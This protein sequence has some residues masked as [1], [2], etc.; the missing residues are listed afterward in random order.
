MSGGGHH[1]TLIAEG[2]GLALKLAFPGKPKVRRGRIGHGGKKVTPKA[3]MSPPPPLPLWVNV[4]RALG[5]GI[6]PATFVVGFIIGG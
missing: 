1:D 4:V 3:P 6:I 2:V 5:I